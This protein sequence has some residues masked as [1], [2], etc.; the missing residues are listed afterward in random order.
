MTEKTNPGSLARN[1][2]RPM[3]Q[4]A[5][6]GPALFGLALGAV[7]LA[8]ELLGSP[9]IAQSK[10]KRLP[11]VPANGEMGFVVESFHPAIVEGKEA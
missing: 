7:S 1:R 8:P 10:A 3:V 5:L 2:L 9:L 4:A 6:A 11:A